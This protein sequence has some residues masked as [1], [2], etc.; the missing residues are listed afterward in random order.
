[1]LTM[2]WT[3]LLYL[4]D[5]WFGSVMISGRAADLAFK[6][7]PQQPSR[8]DALARGGIDWHNGGITNDFGYSV[9]KV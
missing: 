4:L 1:M 9:S 2:A 8:Q 3:S 6:L 5:L 7:V